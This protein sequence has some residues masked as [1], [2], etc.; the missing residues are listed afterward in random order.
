MKR[1]LYLTILALFFFACG[2]ETLGVQGDEGE[3]GTTGPTGPQGEP[4]S[5][6]AKGAKGDPGAPG[7]QG[8]EGLQGA[9]GPRGEQGPQ[10]LPGADGLPGPTGPT[11][12]RGTKG[13]SG[14]DGSPGAQGE[15]GDTGENGAAGAEG[16]QGAP[17]LPGLDGSTVK[18]VDQN[19]KYVGTTGTPTSSHVL[20]YNPLNGYWYQFSVHTGRMDLPQLDAF[21]TEYDC[22]GATFLGKSVPEDTVP[23]RVVFQRSWYADSYHVREDDGQ[24]REQGGNNVSRRTKDGC[25]NGNHGP[26]VLGLPESAVT[27]ISVPAPP[28][29]IIGP[30]VPTFQ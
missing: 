1:N 19:D 20:Y 7:E 3:P 25:I 21:H 28:I 15:K 13:A 29:G 16:P 5:Q 22:G 24:M 4:G 2:S 23:P 6:G 30:L 17:G 14:S 27:S 18:W 12:P 11:G 9:Q 10:G 8:A 26:I